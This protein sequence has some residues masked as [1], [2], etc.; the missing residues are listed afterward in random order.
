[1]KVWRMRRRVALWV[2]LLWTVVTCM[3][4]SHIGGTGGGGTASPSQV[5]WGRPVSEID[6]SAG[7]SFHCSGLSTEIFEDLFGEPVTTRAYGFKGRIPNSECSV[8]RGGPRDYTLY[9][10]DFGFS[11]RDVTPNDR[12]GIGG[13]DTYS[14]FE[15]AGV[16]GS[17]EAWVDTGE[18]ARYATAVFVCGDRYMKTQFLRVSDVNGDPREALISLVEASTPWLCGDEPIPG[19]DEPMESYRPPSVPAT[20][21]P[22]TDPEDG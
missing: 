1:M 9:Y 5:P 10:S 7:E 14:T 20:A 11:A 4:C 17:G 8:R 15:I 2:S 21:P 3:G 22:T 6:F 12:S 19:L 18:K 16:E 13:G